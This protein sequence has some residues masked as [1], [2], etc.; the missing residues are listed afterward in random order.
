MIQKFSAVVYTA[1]RTGSHLIINN[2]CR[3]YHVT[4][5][6]DSD[7]SIV[8]GI[9]HTHNPMYV[10]TTDNFVAVISRRRNLFDSILSTELA[11][12]TN[13]FVTY[14]KKEITPFAIDLAKF[15]N[16]YFFQKA[17]YQAIDRTRYNKV[18]DVYY[19]DLISNPNCLLSDFNV[20][21][22]LSVT[23]KSPYNYYNL[24]IN[25][26]KLKE[27]FQELEQKSI[28]PQEIEEF[29]KTVAADIEDIRVNYN[30]NRP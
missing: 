16:C 11:K 15:K 20:K 8:D 25:I 12:I 19:E 24:V 7:R 21:I 2:L 28:T 6:L 14:T 4:H 3:H 22:D 13:E 23:E 18:V 29:K 10:P 9:V 27:I 26:K 1:G 30:G 17:F 5:Q